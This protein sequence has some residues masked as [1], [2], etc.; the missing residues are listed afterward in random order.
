MCSPCSASWRSSSASSSSTPACTSD[1]A[2][3]TRG[4]GHG[5][6]VVERDELLEGVLERIV[7]DVNRAREWAVERQDAEEQTGDPASQDGDHDGVDSHILQM[8]KTGEADRDDA[9]GDQQSPED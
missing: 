7:A 4:S 2:R 5:A 1:V 8:E 6:A 9:T 3:R